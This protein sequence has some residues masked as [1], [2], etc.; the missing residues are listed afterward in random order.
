MYTVH[1]QSRITFLGSFYPFFTVP[2][3]DGHMAL[4][5]K[6]LGK[7]TGPDWADK[8]VYNKRQYAGQAGWDSATFFLP[9]EEK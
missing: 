7:K 3:G 2:A 4:P 8:T 6:Q 5:K 1:S 9:L